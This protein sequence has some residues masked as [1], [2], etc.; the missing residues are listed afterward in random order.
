MIRRKNEVEVH[1]CTWLLCV[2]SSSVCVPS[3]VQLF[4]THWTSPP[5]S[6]IH[7]IF[8]AKILE[9]VA[10]SF[11]QGIFATQV[12]NS[13][14]L[15]LL[16]RRQMLYPLSHRGSPLVLSNSLRPHGL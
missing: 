16:C 2:I 12:L 7:G 1:M 3:C 15:C 13:R 6:S 10:R 9:W 11:F 4:A 14:L 5:G 8:Q